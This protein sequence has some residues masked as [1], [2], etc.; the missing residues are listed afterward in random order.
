MSF[1][2]VTFELNFWPLRF[3]LS[4]PTRN[5]CYANFIRTLY[6]LFKLILCTHIKRCSAD[7]YDTSTHACTLYTFGA[8]CCYLTNEQSSIE[9]KLTRSQSIKTDLVFAMCCYVDCLCTLHNVTYVVHA[10]MLLLLAVTVQLICGFMCDK[11]FRTKNNSHS[12]H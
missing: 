1:V 4:I 6:A 11:C 9:T 3:T 2:F 8:Q 5:L 10:L 7:D 12:H